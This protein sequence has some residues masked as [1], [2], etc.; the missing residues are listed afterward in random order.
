MSVSSWLDSPSRVCGSLC[1]TSVVTLYNIVMVLM[2]FF[3]NS[4]IG[5]ASALPRDCNDTKAL[6]IGHSGLNSLG[7]SDEN[8]YRDSK[9]RES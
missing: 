5:S 1:D 6:S 7:V 2:I 4:Y 9:R 3:F 8:I